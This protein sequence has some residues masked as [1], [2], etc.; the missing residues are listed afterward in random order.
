MKAIVYDR[1]GPP[2][3]LRHEDIE[4]PA[5]AVDQ[6]LIQVR[7]SSVNPYDWHFI[8]GTPSLIRLFTG[9]RAPK[10]RRLGADV[11][12]VV[13]AIGRNVTSFKVGDAV[14][15]T[16]KGAF[17]EYV[18]A[19]PSTLALKPDNLTWEQAATAPIAGITALQGLRDKCGDLASQQVLINGASG[20]VGTFA[21]QIAKSF[22]AHVTAVCSTRNIGLVR[23]FGADNIIDYTR[24]DLLHC[25]LRFDVLFDLVGNLPLQSCLRVLQPRGIYIGC[26]GG[27]PD[28]RSSEMLTAMLQ[29]LLLR[30]FTSRKM[31]GL[32]ARVNTADLNVLADLMR[33][34]KVTP[35]LDR[36]YPL[37]ETASAIRY[38][39]Q[40]HA[41]GK[42]AITVQ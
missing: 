8:R 16:A 10:S 14:F 32:L 28:R 29:S 27:S 11:A 42:V 4:M 2:E 34:G 1:Y 35:V 41:R 6:V 21:L 22:G 40:G 33:S 7:A 17:A 15:G 31:P 26:G 39:E 37:R 25:D 3:V 38:I 5:P 13:A 12:G 36:T 24:E 18:C 9:L 20:G 23:S 19:S 30:P